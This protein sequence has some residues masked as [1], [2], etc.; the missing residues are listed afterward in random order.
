M[1]HNGRYEPNIQGRT[2]TTDRQNEEDFAYDLGHETG[3][4]KYYS[5]SQ[6]KHHMSDYGRNW[7]DMI[8]PD[9]NRH[10][11]EIINGRAKYAEDN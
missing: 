11:E 4:K 3:I 9:V 5:S 10:Y 1:R 7:R 6:I 2:L 8:R